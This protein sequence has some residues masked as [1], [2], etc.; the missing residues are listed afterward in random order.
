VAERLVQRGVRAGVCPAGALGGVTFAAHL[1]H[2]VHIRAVRREVP[3]ARAAATR[4]DHVVA[5][6]RSQPEGK[7]AQRRASVCVV[8]FGE[9][10]QV[11]AALLD[12]ILTLQRCA[13]AKMARVRLAPPRSA[14]HQRIEE[15]EDV[16]Q[17]PVFATP[18]RCQPFAEHSLRVTGIEEARYA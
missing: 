11:D 17:R 2:L 6:R 12:Q 7:E 5:H 1:Q 9:R 14:A 18:D 13:Q 10:A 3:P 8:L 16:L 15:R 4:L